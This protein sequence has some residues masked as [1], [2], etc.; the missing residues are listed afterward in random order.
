MRAIKWIGIGIGGLGALLLLTLGV[1]FVVVQLKINRSITGVGEPV[2][3]RA[4]AATIAEG[5]RLVVA[6]GCVDC[7]GDNLGGAVFINDPLLGRVAAA[8]LTAGAGG[9]GASY[10]ADDFERAI[11][12]GVGADGKPLLIMPSHEYYPM[13]DAEVG[14]IIAFLQGGLEP[15]DNPLPDSGL[16]PLGV[17][18]GTL[19]AIE[20]T[21]ASLIDESA[22]RESPAPGPTIEYGRY[23]AVGCTGCHGGTLAGGVSPVPGMPPSANLTP[24]Q[25]SGIGA[26]SEADFIRAM[27]EG[28]RPDGSAI[29]PAMPWRN[30]G[31]MN[32][33]ELQA[34]FR[35]LHSLDPLPEG[36]Q[37]LAER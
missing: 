2:T 12:H 6:R 33:T 11:R 13:S 34:L 31:K 23:L 32:D 1:M 24:D 9:V 3:V 4:D 21:P 27:R 25:A 30:L 29:D 5:R 15:V 28:V 14:A 19:G 36:A 26:W 16:G 17:V 22:G 10:T 8:N 7:H 37:A 18:L 20:L 35:Y